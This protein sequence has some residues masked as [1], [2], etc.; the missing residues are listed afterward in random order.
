[1]SYTVFDDNNPYAAARLDMS[2]KLLERRSR[3]NRVSRMP[4]IGRF[5]S[6]VLH[7]R[8]DKELL[9]AHQSTRA[10][11][12]HIQQPAPVERITYPVAYTPQAATPEA[13]PFDYETD[14]TNLQLSPVEAARRRVDE[15]FRTSVDSQVRDDVVAM[16]SDTSYRLNN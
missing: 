1:M 11:L 15:I 2:S 10:A 3:A 8:I 16:Q 13:K 6:G 5:V 12:A 7:E 14:D 4:L 9:E